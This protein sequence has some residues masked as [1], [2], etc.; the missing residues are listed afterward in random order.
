MILYEVPWLEAQRYLR[1][2]KR[3]H[4]PADQ[5]ERQTGPLGG[6]LRSFHDGLKRKFGR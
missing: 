6:P 3:H 1:L 2:I 4:T 5:Q